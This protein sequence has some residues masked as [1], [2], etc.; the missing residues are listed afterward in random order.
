[1]NRRNSFLK[2]KLSELAWDEYPFFNR[3][4]S[5]EQF[6]SVLAQSNGPE[7]SQGQPYKKKWKKKKKSQER[8]AN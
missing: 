7:Y 1:M 8:I 3:V 4:L 6:A 2:V 5:L